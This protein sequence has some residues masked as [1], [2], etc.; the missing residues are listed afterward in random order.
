MTPTA[1]FPRAP[2]PDY[3]AVRMLG[4][5]HGITPCSWPVAEATDATFVFC[6]AHAARQQRRLTDAQLAQID[7]DLT[8]PPVPWWAIFISGM[9]QTLLGLGA[10]FGLVKI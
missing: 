4:D 2:E 1:R 3:A 6:N 8:P 7:R 10:M 9:V 5:K